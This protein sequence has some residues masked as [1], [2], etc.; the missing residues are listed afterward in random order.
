[1]RY[2]LRRWRRRPGFALTA[3]GTLALG[4]AAATAVFSVVDAVLLRPL[5]WTS[6][7]SLVVVHGV[8]P[9][10]RNSPATAPTWDRWYISYPGWDALRT[11]PVFTDVAA[12]SGVNRLMWTIGD[13]GT[14]LI[15]IANVSSAFLPMLGVRL[16]HGRHFTPEEDNRTTDSIILSNEI[17]VR[18]FG[19][20]PDIIGLRVNTPNA[21]SGGRYPRTV[22]GVLE[23]GFRFGA[24]QPDALLPVGIPAEVS[25]QYPSPSLRI[26]ARL[27]PGASVEAA[28]SAAASLVSAAP[29][30]QRGTARVVSLVDEQI[31]AARR[32]L[33]LLLAAAGLLLLVACSNVAG[34]LLAEARVRRH[35]IAVRTALGGSSVRLV[36]QLLVEHTMLA[37]AGTLLGLIV[38]GWLVSALVAIAP[39]GLPRIDSVVVDV[40][41]AAFAGV[42]GLVTLLL[43]GVIP[44]MSLARVPVSRTLAEGGRDGV[45][46]RLLGARTIVVVQMALALVLIIGATLFAETLF[47]LRAEPLGF[48][49][50]GLAVAATMFTGPRYGD[51]GPIRQFRELRSNAE[52]FSRFMIRQAAIV[53]NDLTD[54]VLARLSVLPGVTA[55][56]GSSAVPFVIGPL[57]LQMIAE[58][59]T[60]EGR[61]EAWRQ[62]VT[63][64]YFKAMGIRTIDGRLF[65]PSD[66]GDE[67]VIVVSREFARRF[68]PDGAVGRMVRQVY[69][70]NYELSAF[71]RIIGVVDDVKRGAFTDEMRPTMYGFDRQ[72]GAITHFLVRTS[73]DPS[74]ILPAVREAITSVSQRLVITTTAT[75][76]DRMARSVADQRF[77][78][79]LSVLF[80]T[81]ALALAAVG[82]YGLAAR[83]AVDRRREFAVRIALGARPSDVRHLVVW[84]AMWIIGLGVALGV[85]AAWWAA[86]VA[87]SMLYG[88]TATAPHVFSLSA[89]VLG[90][91]ALVATIGPAFRAGHTN[92]IDVIRN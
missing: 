92:P 56:A 78:A 55:A 81:T 39:E 30:E 63:A 29:N 66:A 57:S 67:D 83:R 35:E 49:P 7:E 45:A 59:S 27:A 25:R 16:T 51:P 24:E 2:A 82:L 21:S 10:R 79:T 65:G 32:P 91:V 18:Y 73:G 14:E 38:S 31:G 17:W 75:L 84:D 86:Q 72:A 69:G 8:Y 1:M 76:E 89:V 61:H 23:P 41:V 85:P 71:Y 11:S 47:R 87:A 58:G 36:R 9:N 13:D 90:G 34:L 12:W 33:W 28:S 22:V 74:A 3:I 15:R 52:A 42:T 19:G 50:D 37:I 70:E 40:R 6:P 80:G 88:V 20:R 62:I 77:R 64:D 44:A 60:S 43:F 54:R 4:I 26:L 68:Y 5:P 53:N 46:S 48:Q